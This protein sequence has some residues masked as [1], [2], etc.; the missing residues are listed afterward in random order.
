MNVSFRRILPPLC[1]LFLL[2]CLTIHSSPALSLEPPIIKGRTRM[3]CG[4]SQV[5]SVMNYQTGNTY[6][7][8]IESGGGSLSD[9]IGER[10]TYT[11]PSSNPDCMNSPT[12]RVSCCDNS[13]DTL[14]VGFNC[15]HNEAIAY[16]IWE[17]LRENS[18]C[19]QTACEGHSN[20]WHT[21]CD[22]IYRLNQY[23]CNGVYKSWDWSC[24]GDGWTCLSSGCDYATACAAADMKTRTICI[25]GTSPGKDEVGVYYDVRS[26]EQ[27]LNGCC[28]E[29]LLPGYEPKP[30]IPGWVHHGFDASR[31]CP[32]GDKSL[33]GNPIRIYNGNNIEAEEDLRFSS[34][35]RRQLIFKR[36]YNSK[37]GSTG[38]LGYG[39]THTY[40]A[41]LDPSY[42]FEDTVYLR[43]VDETGRGVYFSDA[44]SG[45]YV[46]AFKEQTTVEVEAG[47][48]VWYR[49]DDS[50]HAF[51][52]QGQLIW[53]EDELGNRQNLAYDA[54]NRLETVTDDASG[55]VLSFHYNADNLLDQISGPVTAAVPDGI[56]ASYGYD[57]NQ[58]LVFVTY[59]DGS[60]FNYIYGDPND[61]HNLTEKHDK[62][63]HLLSSWAYDAYDRA[64]E[65][66]T[67]DGQGVDIDYVSQNEVRVTDAYGVTR[68]Y[69]IGDID[70]RKL[71][72]H[73]DGPAGCP[74]CGQEVVRLEYDS[75]LR[76]IEVEYANGLINQYDDFDS[77]G[78][79][80]TVGM[81]VGTPDEKTITYTFH[82][83]ISA[84][85]SQTEASILGA[86]DKITLWDY[87][88]DGNTTANENPTRLLS[89]KIE[90][91]FTKDI[92][93]TVIAFEYVTAYTYNTKGQVLKIDGPE[94]GEQDTTTFSYD[95]TTGD[96]LTVTRPVVGTTVY[97]ET[98]YSEY[99]AAGQ[100]GRVTDANGNALTYTYDGHGRI[101]TM[102][103]EA[104]G[105]TTYDYNN[106]G[107]LEEVTQANSVTSGFAY[108]ATYGR[109]TRITDPLGNYI[110]YSY[111]DQG[112]RTELSHFDPGDQRRFWKRFDY[113][114]TS[115]PGK[116]WKE[117]N[118]DDTYTE[119]TYD[120][121]GN[122]SSV[123]DAAGKVTSYDY[124]LFDRLTTV[125]QP[126][127]V[128]TAYAYDGQDNLT[129]VTDA[130]NHITTYVYDDLGRLVTTTSPDTGATRYAYDASGD[131]VSKADAKGNTIRY[132]YD[133]L[134]RLTGIHFPD[135]SQDITYT[136]DQGANSKGRLTGMT[137]PSGTYTYTYDALGNLLTEEK[138]INT[139]TYTTQ[140]AYDPAGI[141]T[142]MTY[143]DGRTVDYELDN[144]GRV[145][146]AT[147]IKDSVTTILAENVSYL[148]F[149]PL[150]SLTYGNGTALS[151]TFDQLYRLI[152][153]NAGSV[154]SLGYTPDPVGNITAITDNL[155]ASRN[156]TF[157]YDDLYR[158][159]SAAGIYGSNGYTY[160]K[161]GNRLTKTVDGQTDTYAY[162]TNTNRLSQITGA[163][164]Q[165]FSH[166]A[167]G[168]T[169]SMDTKTLVYNQNN[170]LIQAT[171]DSTTLGDYVYNG[172]GQRI[173]KAAG[174]DTT[175][176]HYDRFGNLI[177]ESTASGQFIAQ[178][179]YL[180]N[181]RLAAIAQEA[182]QEITVHV[183]TN[184]GRDLSAV[185]V[186]AFTEAGSYTGNSAVTDEEGLV[187]FDLSEFSDGTYRFRADYLSYQFWSEVITIPGTYS[188]TVEIAEEPATVRVIEGGSPAQGVNVYL[189]NASGSYLGI[190]GTTDE[191]GEVIF[192]FPTDKDFKCRA[193]ILGNQ[194][195]S[196]TITIVSGGANEYEIDTGGGTLTVTVDKGEGSPIVNI[197]IY[198][199]SGQ[200]SYLGLSD[201]TDSWGSAS[202]DVCSGDFKV[203][204]DYLGY[205]FWSDEVTLSSDENLLLSIPHQDVT[206][207]V[208]GD[209]N[210]NVES[211]E[212]LNVYLFTAS[213][214]YLGQYHTTDEQGEVTFNLP[215]K[216]Y[217]AR[218]DYLSQQHWSEVF[219]WTD[220][221]ITINEAV[222][223]VTVTNMGLLLEGVNVYVFSSAG[224]YLGLYEV[225]DENGEVLFRLPAGAYN[226]CADYLGSQYWSGVSALIAHTTNPVSISTGGGSFGLTVLKAQDD[227][228]VGVSCYLFNGSGSY[229][230][231][232]GVTS[233]AGEVAFNLADGT[234]KIRVDYLGYQFWTDLF[235]VPDTLS[236]TY[237]ISHQ[238]VTIT[239]EGDY[240]G[241]V[242]A[243]NGLKVYLFSASGSYLRRYQTTDEQ[244]QV[245]FILPEMDYKVRADYL[246]QQHWS[247][248]FN[249]AD[250]TITINEGVAEVHVLQGASPLE[251]VNV[252]LF[253]SSG[254]YLGIHGQSDHD[255]I[256]SF[257]LPEGTYK[258]RGDF[259]G[260]QY[261][262]TEPVNAD[263]VNIVNLNTGGGIFTLTVEEQG[264]IPVI[265]I[266]VYVFTS[267]G[268]YL[269][270]TSQTDDQ[271]EVSFDLSDGDY[272][273]R[274]DYLGYQFW[275]NVS[276]V[277]TTLSDVLTIPHHNVPITVE[278]LYQAP[279][280]TVEG[281]RVYLFKESGSYLG[282]YAD[283]SA[284]GEVVFSLPEQSYKVRADY[285][286]YQFWSDPFV[287]SDTN[288]SV[289]INHGLAVLHVTKGG[290]DVV[291]APVYLFKASGSYL[292]KHERTDADGLA[293]FLLPDQPYKFRVDYDGIQYWSDEITVIL[294]EE[295]SIELDLDLLALDLTNNPNPVRFNGVPPESKPEKV[296]VASLGSLTG[297]LTQ[298]VVSQIPGET[299]YYYINDH[300]G[301]PQKM[302]DE[303]GMVVWSADYMPF[304]EAD[305]TVD[306]VE[307]NFRFPGQYYDSET[308]LHYN[309]HRYYDP[310]TGRYMTPDPIGL[311]G[312]MNLYPYGENN[313][314]RF[315]D[316]LGLQA[317]VYP[318]VRAPNAGDFVGVINEFLKFYNAVRL[319][320]KA[321]R[322]IDQ[323]R[324]TVACG[325]ITRAHICFN[326]GPPPHGLR[327]GL[328]DAVSS[329]KL[330]CVG[331]NIVG[332]KGCPCEGRT[333]FW[334]QG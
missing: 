61:V 136:Y 324:G 260:G 124:D 304:G 65:S 29:A 10:V 69:G 185:P 157:A 164:P 205:Q 170:R 179:F 198:L 238:Y 186:Y 48:Y 199:F 234:Y 291:D 35:N 50:R 143:P 16:E 284:Q 292:G 22:R 318:G 211:I 307:N 97:S 273:F 162:E 326:P 331:I 177:G 327:V 207:T 297:L 287:W 219:N 196:A 126:G 275:S 266:P 59:A 250:K 298:A 96:L 7:W 240:N 135:S 14:N 215:N 201:Q 105:T 216:E 58:N 67:R 79:A 221:A 5:L 131:L 82:P 272:K 113:Q 123:T 262:A 181:T 150:A 217:K 248:V 13:S 63:G 141:L 295:N 328:G 193:D 184:T 218:A 255:G 310:S 86:G 98:V 236:L 173:R 151:K 103:N 203:R 182:A 142:S 60:G 80:Q 254:S 118:P 89:R 108:D 232:Y 286:G 313:P 93:G 41:S 117:I 309:Y 72:T 176:Y 94:P 19:A 229:L 269:G 101:K 244:G 56:W 27:K 83:Q 44:G 223:S 23:D 25:A 12:I 129:T 100:V 88:D 306:T 17:F 107:E 231:E 32:V 267:G 115:F 303:S 33:V 165:S 319:T 11:A 147:S 20:W 312:G 246:S 288:T 42:E 161:V 148:P 140:Y 153:M 258:F 156:Q 191:N 183:S 243:R 111:D 204:A 311:E 178:Y 87:D 75:A 188:A 317:T 261:W 194:F 264:G 224:S 321:A 81:A 21:Y 329:P 137:D 174:A 271:G 127:S 51:N 66:F 333:S 167:N 132:T 24:S 293:E 39:W 294:H 189:F 31:A 160:D 91:G 119:Y 149:G 2:F 121:S 172:N 214:S 257:R 112:N 30:S 276:T 296:M 285:L 265:N 110:Q 130:E 158:L 128:V 274:A 187:H 122:I 28:P 259:Q 197:R 190:Y 282:K 251:N 308:G 9:T 323:L 300:L 71:V 213:G 85:L 74:G 322:S 235:T 102:T 222:A 133:D 278:G 220:K 116:L 202:F 247:E 166:D 206:V 290:C 320:N 114:G 40:T 252:Y 3:A 120:A 334:R 76:I 332:T 18:S 192:D 45:H 109:L 212:G 330:R 139:V 225:T 228:L 200:G 210:D 256:V 4:E 270:M 62:M 34:P 47:D 145:T 302:I 53:I 289:T 277:P 144:A 230:G 301:T 163:N 169:T 55:R 316:A 26:A 36:F 195:F 180:D 242:E 77:R 134:N 70:G 226:F 239:V 8:T 283:T 237:A 73:I 208:Q 37:S 99:D 253:S 43:I 241:D 314:I 299:V 263:E 90:Q 249:W 38:P 64:T 106:A 168:N 146:R 78:N 233:S 279:A 104:D 46:G 1:C 92:A 245:G 125:T 57:A 305:V 68:T 209:Y 84:K 154:Q 15:L 281:I 95:S 175:V 315:L 52:A 268:S 49:L 138:I 54:S 159:T 152:D 155:D 280:E 325:D 227:P 6:T 171:E